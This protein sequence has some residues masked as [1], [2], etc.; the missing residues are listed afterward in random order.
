MY[1]EPGFDPWDA[2]EVREVLDVGV[3]QV[4][5]DRI[6]DLHRWSAKDGAA[7][8]VAQGD[9]VLGKRFLERRDEARI[10]HTDGDIADRTGVA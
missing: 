9:L 10:G 1:P 7:W 6:E 4:L 5:L 8:S 2:Y 3:A